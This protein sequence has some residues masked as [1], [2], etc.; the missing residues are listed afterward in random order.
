ME[1]IDALKQACLELN[2]SFE[3]VSKRG[4]PSVQAIAVRKR[5]DQI[6]LSTPKEYV[7]EKIEYVSSKKR[8]SAGDMKPLHDLS[9]DVDLAKVPMKY[10]DNVVPTFLKR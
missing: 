1:K 8:I 6:M 3:S 7:P 2:V 10:F 4:R 9:F 5:A